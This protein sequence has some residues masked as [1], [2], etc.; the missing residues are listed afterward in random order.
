MTKIYLIRHAEAEGNFYRRIHGHYNSD[1]TARGRLQIEALAERFRDIP[2]DAVY[3]SD[4]LRTQRTAGAILKYHPQ[5]KLNIEPRLKEVCMGSWEDEP[6]GNVAQEMPDQLYY[7]GSDPARWNIPGSESFEDLGDRIM[8]IIT[9]L[10]QRHNGQTIACVSHGMAIRTL[11]CRIKGVKSED[12]GAVLHGDNTCVALLD[13]ENGSISIEYYNDNSHLQNG[14]STFADQSWWRESEKKD[15]ANLR[16]V[17]MDLD[18]SGDAGLYA[19]SY[20][21]AWQQAHGTLKGF[22]A[23]PY[24]Q[25]AKAVSK[26]DSQ[27]LLKAFS[28]DNFAGIIELDPRR[29]EKQGAGWISFC[30]VTESL[31]GYG[32]GPQLMG[33]AISYYR[34]AGR[35]ALALHVAQCNNRAVHFYEKLDFKHVA[36]EE[37][38]L[39]PLLLM[40]KSICRP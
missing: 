30:Y 35:Q 14:L 8:G 9:E 32:Y 23:K 27:T 1:V 26:N 21:D 3:A 25:S 38:I 4:L 39:S 36:T 18:D 13:V 29:M 10:A 22:A 34:R 40:E 33:H 31:R 6:W 28:G 2:I 17:P 24:L 12:I 7:F 11:M 20:A 16:F 19:D 5:L 15:V 37:G